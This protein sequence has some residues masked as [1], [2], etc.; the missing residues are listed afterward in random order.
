MSRRATGQ[1]TPRP[2]WRLNARRA[3]NCE[4]G[5]VARTVLCAV[6]CPGLFGE[7][8]QRTVRTTSLRGLSNG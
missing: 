2:L 6:H 8:A 7:A 4:K 5:E 1:G 3:L